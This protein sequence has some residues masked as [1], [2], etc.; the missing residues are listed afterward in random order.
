MGLKWKV[1][2]WEG[3]KREG[4]WEWTRVPLKHTV[5]HFPSLEETRSLEVP[6][7]C[8]PIWHYAWWFSWLF[9]KTV[10]LP[11]PGSVCVKIAK[12]VWWYLGSTQQLLPHCLHGKE[13]VR[14]MELRVEGALPLWSNPWKDSVLELL[15]T[16]QF[17]HPAPNPP[18][19]EVRGEATLPNFKQQ[20]L[21][22]ASL[23]MAP[24]WGMTCGFVLLY[25]RLPQI[26]WFKTIWISYLTVL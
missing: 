17:S 25:N 10:A 26:Q 21:R 12:T 16:T 8:L 7:S 23:R 22:S 11:P 2:E 5:G 4:H 9:L 20:P 6:S 13:G 15:S 14:R 1:E 3:P 18:P 24:P 19:A